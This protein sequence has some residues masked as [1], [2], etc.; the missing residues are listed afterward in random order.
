[1]L[2]RLGLALLATT[3]LMIGVPAFAAPANISYTV[4][5]CNPSYPQR[6]VAVAADGSV[7]VT[8]TPS[9]TG[10]VNLK[11][12]NGAAVNVGTGAAGTGTQ[13][14]TTS[15][16][17]TI[18]TV[19]NPVGIKGADGSAI[20]SVSN[21]IPVGGLAAAGATAIGNPIRTGGTDLSGNVQAQ[22]YIATPIGNTNMPSNVPTNGALPILRNAGSS[23]YTVNRTF[24]ATAKDLGAGDGIQ[25]VI[26]FDCDDISTVTP[27][28]NNG[29]YAR[30]SCA[31]RILLVHEAGNSFTNITTN[32][33]TVVKASAGTLLGLL[34][35]TA[36][37]GSTAA[38]YNNTT[39]TGAKIGTFST[40][41]QTA[42]S[43][44]NISASVGICITT[45][46]A[47]A[48]DITA[49]WR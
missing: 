34:V 33:D 9:G 49:T 16:D 43:A 24:Q 39:C 48:A 2:K 8:S 28:E 32:T 42:L 25:P 40:A 47:G 17:S 26:A 1:M 46:G 20:A 18:G 10:D 44:L 29:T 36:G 12:V 21:P 11:Q 22:G 7:P 19:T 23:T 38:I 5:V 4:G 37:T 15:T 41:A 3:F 13:R 35:N 45:A 27:T 30:V 14:V 6:C 31:D